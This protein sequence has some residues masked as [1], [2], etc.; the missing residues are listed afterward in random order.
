[1]KDLISKLLTKD[2]NQRLGCKS[3]NEV[4]SHPFFDGIDFETLYRSSPP[5]DSRQKML[6]LQ[7]KSEL[8]YLPG[9][10]RVAER[11]K[12]QEIQRDGPILKLE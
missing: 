11:R 5:L 8:A 10:S 4:K 6:S 1:M 3:I 2:P 12:D 7:K 9:R